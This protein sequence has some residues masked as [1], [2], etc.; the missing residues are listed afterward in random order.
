MY[1]FINI[2]ANIGNCLSMGRLNVPGFLGN[3]VVTLISS[4]LKSSGHLSYNS[5]NTFSVILYA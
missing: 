2:Y 4:I 3:V 5:V 1:E